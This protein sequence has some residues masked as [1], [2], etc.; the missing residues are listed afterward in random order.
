MRGFGLDVFRA[1]RVELVQD[2]P[3]FDANGDGQVDDNDLLFAVTLRSGHPEPG[4]IAARTATTTTWP[5]FVQDD[6][7]L[8]LEPHAEPR[9][10]L[11]DRHRT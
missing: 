6:W 10:A 4:I 7:R 2:F 1:G 8:R 11:R 5:L 9:P 3:E